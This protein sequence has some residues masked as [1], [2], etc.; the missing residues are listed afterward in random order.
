MELTHLD[1]LILS[2]WGCENYEQTLERVTC[3]AAFTIDEDI[4]EQIVLLH[5]RLIDE[6]SKTDYPEQYAISKAWYKS[7]KNE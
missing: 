3:L 2:I 7:M 4:K 5:D 1:M 6:C